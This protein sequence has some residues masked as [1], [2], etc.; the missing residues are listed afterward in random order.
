MQGHIAE[1]MTDQI[2]SRYIQEYILENP[3]K[4][5]IDAIFEEIC[6]VMLQ[7]STDAF[8]NFSVQRYMSKASVEQVE[9]LVQALRGSILRLSLQ[10]Y[11]C[12]VAQGLLDIVNDESK[13][14]I[15]SEMEPHIAKCARDQSE[16]FALMEW[17]VT[18]TNFC[19]DCNHVIQKI[20]QTCPP[21]FLHGMLNA[22]LGHVYSFATHPYAT[23]ILQ[24]LVHCPF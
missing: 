14:L 10:V 8:A 18:N 16:P 5:D 23:R 22:L 2:G 1:F 6:P 9:A 19:G 11:G 24:R 12:R 20:V 15:I 13:L 3:S 4:D 7:L 17:A 21:D